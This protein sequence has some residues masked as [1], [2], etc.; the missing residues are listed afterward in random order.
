MKKTDKDTEKKDEKPTGTAAEAEEQETDTSADES[1]GEE[2]HEDASDDHKTEE[3]GGDADGHDQEE[4]DA[5]ET[6]GQEDPGSDRLR[7]E[8]LAAKCQLAA[9]A[10]GVSPGM[11]QDAV[12]LATAE[13]QAT[14]E[15]TEES[16]TKAIA[17][18]LKRHPEWKAA[19][20]DKKGTGGFKLGFDRDSA[21][22]KQGTEVPKNTKRWN[23]FK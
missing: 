2:T 21:A 6:G 15:A 3:D 13:A 11:I 16:V 9:Y 14:G 22:S 12:T 17:N 23:R 18:V 19:A 1:G 20:P 4:P 7:Q 8:L 10:A 5:Q